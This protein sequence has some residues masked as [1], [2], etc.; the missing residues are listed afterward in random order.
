MTADP[1]P[2]IHTLIL[3]LHAAATFYLLGLGWFV[4][5]VH[6]PLFAEVGREQFPSYERSHVS[7]IT[8]IVAPAMLIEAATACAL[9]AFP[10]P[11]VPLAL[12]WLGLFCLGLIWLSTFLL[13]VPRH[14]ELGSGF[15]ALAH[16]RLVAT[17]WIRT[18]LWSVRG[19]VVF[20]IVFQAAF[21]D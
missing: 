6:Y 20:S 9:I 16:G 11:G 18:T 4:Q 12:A 1:S 14:Q 7:R 19:V 10:S 15:D 8:P 17:N 5:A 13:Q 3:L 2:A 21:A